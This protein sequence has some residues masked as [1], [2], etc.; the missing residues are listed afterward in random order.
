MN[1]WDR[2][3]YQR[4]AQASF[5]HGELLVRFEDGSDIA[6]KANSL[7]PPG[8]QKAEWSDL[9]TNP[10]ELIVVA[11]G[12]ELEIPWSTLR[13]ITD[14]SYS[15][16]LARLADERSRM[17]G[18]RLRELREAKNLSAKEV[19]ERAGISAQSLSRIENGKHDVVFT[20]LQ[21]ILDAMGC[22][23]RDLAE[24][25]D[26]RP[27][28]A[29][30]NGIRP[31]RSLAE[32]A[33]KTSALGFNEEFLEQRIAPRRMFSTGATQVKAA[34]ERLSLLLGC[35]LA[36]L[37][38]GDIDLRLEVAGAFKRTRKAHP[39]KTKAYALYA[40]QL[41]R[42]TVKA[43][44]DI[45]WA[46]VSEAEFVSGF[47]ERQ[48]SPTF[49]SLLNF[50]WDLGI[51]VLPLADSGAFH[52]ACWIIED[53]PIIVLKQRTQFHARWLFDLAHEIGHVLLHLRHDD[54]EILEPQE[55]TPVSDDDPIEEAANDFAHELLLRNRQEDLI[56][57]I[58]EQTKGNIPAFKRAVV[59]IG[60]RNHV[61]VDLMAN[62]LAYRLSLQGLSWWGTAN[63]LQ[64]TEPEPLELARK[65]FMS[66]V[67]MAQ[68]RNEE[69]D[70]LAQALTNEEGKE[71]HYGG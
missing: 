20:T 18:V 43:F 28:I 31:L 24:V 14:R 52:G 56:R 34:I 65:V 13:S 61:P 35:T 38:R 40:Y 51:P 68:L 32:L 29:P 39:V 44:A 33:R 23:L 10:Y 63:N 50:T 41:C 55:I 71:P 60:A 16:H 21:R 36:D 57:M 47:R 27:D 45:P 30:E 59:E 48:P 66:R 69:R 54:H 19:A 2:P 26:A 1:K 4:I 3:E 53:R 49:E 64:Y 67:H 25:H 8:T 7:L 6:V 22:T 11:D 17:I 9:E 15:A 70:L 58:V 62:Y 37:N 42:W 12:K 5:R 46:A